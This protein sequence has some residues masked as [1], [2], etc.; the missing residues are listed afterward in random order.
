[1][2]TYSE[3]R[4]ISGLAALILLG[5]FAAGILSVLL[6]G[7]G[8]YKRLNE[9]DS[10]AYNS[11]TCIQYIATKVRQAP[12]PDA[13][14]VSEFGE[15]DCLR[16]REQINGEEYWTQ[17]YC[18]DGWLM[19]LFAA[20]GAGL[21]PENGEKILQVRNLELSWNG[22]MLQVDLMDQNGTESAIL[23]TPRGREGAVP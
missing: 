7:V 9:R 15:G 1:M 10:Q 19:E 8:V 16:I 21:A 5:V 2:K 22:A 23:L 12:A 20:T 18:F 3:K 14:V 17:I 13:V 4:S 11:R 6:T